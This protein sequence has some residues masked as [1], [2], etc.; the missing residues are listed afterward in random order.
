MKWKLQKDAR[1]G[2]YFVWVRRDGIKKYFRFDTNKR[3]AE[4]ELA[5]LEVRI[6]KGEV[7]FA[8]QTTVAVLTNGKKDMRIEELAVKHLEWVQNN[9]SPGTFKNRQYFVQAFLGFLGPAMVSDITRI[10]LEEFY[11]WARKHHARGE[12][13]GNQIYSHIKT[14][15]RWGEEMEII[16]LNFKRFPPMSYT[17]PETKRL[18]EEVVQLCLKPEPAASES[19]TP[20]EPDEFRDM[21]HFGLLTGLRPKELRTISKDNIR[22]N[23]A[24][25]VFLLIER[26]K[27]SKTANEPKPRSVPLS[28]PAVKIIAR[29]LANHPKAKCLFLNADGGPYT[30][31]TLKTKLKR[32][33]Q[34]LNIKVFAPYALRHTFCSMKS[35]DG[36]E[37]TSLAQLMGHS[38]TRTVQRYISNTFAH[39]QSAVDTLATRLEGIVQGDKKSAE[40]NVE[41][42]KSGSGEGA[43]FGQ[44]VPPDVPPTKD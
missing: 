28:P 41:T 24:G 8:E 12:N 19:G 26:H 14:M 22:H 10:K 9:R 11:A 15:L 34:K 31:Y 39:F 4:Q 1:N 20:Q 6:A 44:N 2:N 35:E 38:S 3:V 33:C 30:R 16:D 32:Y 13:G 27:T 5:E 42:V 29:Q 23:G 40:I 36:M 37:T 21:L 43:G 7:A 17:P 18:N 25:G